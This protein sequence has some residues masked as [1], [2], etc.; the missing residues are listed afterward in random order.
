MR[1]Q[2]VAVGR[3]RPAITNGQPARTR[4]HD[5]LALQS[6]VGN[7][8]VANFVQR[9]R[10]RRSTVDIDDGPDTPALDIDEDGDVDADLAAEYAAPAAA[11][12]GAFLDPALDPIRDA[13]TRRQEAAALESTTQPRGRPQWQS[14]T[15]PVDPTSHFTAQVEARTAR[16]EATTNYGEARRA[17]LQPPV[18]PAPVAPAPAAAPAEVAPVPVVAPPEVVPPVAAP[19]VVADP[20]ATRR[21]AD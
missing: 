10:R 21:A 3:G 6:A 9:A 20:V 8:A 4:R 7:H 2:A 15:G 17:A 18:A 14:R 12:L 5:V 19:P 11:T 13:E 16:D 1:S